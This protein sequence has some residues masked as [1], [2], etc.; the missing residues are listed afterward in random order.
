MHRFASNSPTSES[1]AAG[2]EEWVRT[3]SVP[4]QIVRQL[5]VFSVFGA[6]ALIRF[7][8]LHRASRLDEIAEVRD[9]TRAPDCEALSLMTK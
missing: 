9:R 1:V 4:S 5:L 8:D 2:C 7:S 6:V 3:Y